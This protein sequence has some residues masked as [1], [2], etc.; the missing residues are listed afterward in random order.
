MA[1]KGVES[2]TRA[3]VERARQLL[4]RRVP[5][6]EAT[7]TLRREFQ[8][9]LRSAQGYL[10]AAREARESMPTP[11]RRRTAREHIEE[12][13]EVRRA[14]WLA[15]KHVQMQTEQGIRTEAYSAPELRAVISALEVVNRMM[16]I[17][18][19][20]AESRIR[21]MAEALGAAMW[22]AGQRYVRADVRESFRRALEEAANTI[23]WEAD[24]ERPPEKGS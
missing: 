11:D 6:V 10:Q 2:R 14:A 22:R 17:D 16:G 12:L 3:A 20:T 24:G 13:A 7:T 18:T 9:G 21:E 5:P 8:V 1:I 15:I 23:I 4:A 19:P